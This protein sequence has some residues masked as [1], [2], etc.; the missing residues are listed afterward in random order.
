VIAIPLRSKSAKDVATAMFCHIFDVHGKPG[1]I[2]SDEG[3]KFVIK[4]IKYLYKHWGIKPISTGGYQPQAV[5][6]E[7]FHPCSL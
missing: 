2:H 7:R 6:V 5:A 3:T 1:A 4:G